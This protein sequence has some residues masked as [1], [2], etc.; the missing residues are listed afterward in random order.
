M[1]LVPPQNVEGVRWGHKASGFRWT[2]HEV[3]ALSA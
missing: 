1:L 3:S 2:N